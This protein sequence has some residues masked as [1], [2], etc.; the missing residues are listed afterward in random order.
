ML[1]DEPWE[2]AAGTS[3]GKHQGEHNMSTQRFD[4]LPA[5]DRLGATG[6][7]ISSFLV[8]DPVRSIA[9]AANMSSWETLG[10]LNSRIADRGEEQRS[11]ALRD[12]CSATAEVLYQKAERVGQLLDAGI[13]RSDIPKV[14]AALGESVDI[15]IAVELLR[16]PDILMDIH[17]GMEPVELAPRSDTFSLLYITGRHRNVEPDYQFALGKVPLPGIDDLRR[18]ISAQLS[19][20]QTGEIIAVVE[21]TAEAIRTGNRAGISYTEYSD[22][23]RALAQEPCTCVAGPGFNW[24]VPAE[25]IRSRMGRGFWAVALEEAGLELPS[26]RARFSDADYTEATEAFSGA[27]DHF[28]S[29]KDVASYDSW[30]IAEAAAGRDRPSVVAIRRHFGTWESVIGAVMPSEIEDELDGIVETYKVENNLEYGW[31]RAGELVSEVLGAMPWNSFLSIQYGDDADGRLQPYA[32]ASPSADGVWCEIVS[33]EFLP[34]DLW[35]IGAANLSRDGWSPPDDEVPNWH[36]QGVPPIEAGHHILEGLR[37]GRCCD[38]PTR[39]RW[40]TGV[41]L[42]GPGPDG[43]VTL[44]D[45][46]GGVVQT[47]RNAS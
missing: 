16:S 2:A 22:T 10:I 38:D 5:G 23:A 4:P 15:D 18:L 14:L 44:D 9:R 46:L 43:G 42:G 31:A 11:K 26:E 19:E 36:K 21:T 17:V 40:H 28:G 25:V 32:Q 29:P 1:A 39:L 8:G 33:E 37:Y 35:P 30:V 24:P 6:Q 20:V 45:A 7:I 34:A 41:F 47:L 27:W 13:R 3:N 12:R